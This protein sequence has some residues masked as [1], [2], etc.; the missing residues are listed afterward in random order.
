VSTNLD[1]N[2]PQAANRISAYDGDRDLVSNAIVRSVQK[3]PGPDSVV[4]AIVAA[5]VDA[6]F[7]NWR[8]RRTPKGEA[9]LLS[10]LRRFMPAG[11]VDG[12][13]RKTFGLG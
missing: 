4:A 5:I 6:A 3:A 10:R 7:G 1:L 2:T 13:L 12:S 9:S 8:L 11:P